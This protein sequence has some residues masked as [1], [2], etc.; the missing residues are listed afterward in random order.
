MY[1]SLKRIDFGPSEHWGTTTSNWSYNGWLESAYELMFADCVSLE[2]LDLTCIKGAL[3]C[4][5][6]FKG[7][8]SLKEINLEYAGVGR[9]NR[10]GYDSRIPAQPDLT[11]K[12]NIFEDCNELSQIKLSA[13]GWPA[14]ASAQAFRPRTHGEKLTSP[15]RILNFRAM[16]YSSISNQITPAHG[17]PTPSSPSRETA[18]LRVFKPFDGNRGPSSTLTKMR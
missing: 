6:T 17:S 18:V 8:T 13:E 14:E 5:S 3:L 16:N 10:P 11:G 12:A 15:T 4:S 9:E 7:C 1:L 2:S